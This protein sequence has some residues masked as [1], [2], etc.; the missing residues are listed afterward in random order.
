MTPRTKILSTALSVLAL[1]T[2]VNPAAVFAQ[3]AAPAVIKVNTRIVVLDVTVRDKKGNL[4]TGLS[5]DDFAVTEDGVPQT[6]RSFETTD[7]HTMPAPA[8]PG[9]AVVTS[10]ADLKKIG[11]APVTILVLDELN[12][13]WTDMAQV[14]QALDKYLAAQPAVLAQPTELL[15]VG[16]GKFAVIHDFTQDRGAIQAAFKKHPSSIPTQLMLDDGSGQA[17]PRMSQTLGSL[18]QIAEATQSYRGRKNVIWV[19]RGFPSLNTQVVDDDETMAQIYDAIRKTTSRMLASRMT[20]N[21]IDPTMLSPTIQGDGDPT[22]SMDTLTT[23][24][25]GQ[26][27]QNMSDVNFTALAPATGGRTFW[28]DSFIDKEIATSVRE[29]AIY[30]TLSYSPTNKTEDPAKLRKIH[31]TMRDKS[32]TATTRGGYFAEPL[33]KTPEMVK[34]KTELATLKFDLNAAAMSNMAYTALTVTVVPDKEKGTKLGESGV[35]KVTIGGGGLEWR[36][37]S[38]GSIAEVSIMVQSFS[39][40]NKPLEGTVSEHNATSAASPAEL[41]QGSAAFLVPVKIPGNAQR[42]RFVVRDLYNGHIGTADLT[43]P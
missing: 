26:G 27:M 13:P 5:K 23:D 3:E 15:F 18:V 43:L 40:K 20:L 32:L 8:T 30:Y 31:I 35:Y 19:G 21:T 9:A 4:V 34:E 25:E 38:T 17:A 7:E 6:I 29:G 39:G 10:T 12:T 11:D 28:L 2:L 33:E 42:L 22:D 16:S 24:N 41:A 37:Q 14:R 36:P 1:F